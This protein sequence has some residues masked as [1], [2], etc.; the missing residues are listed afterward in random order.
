MQ[1]AGLPKGAIAI[2]IAE[3]ARISFPPGSDVWRDFG[4][5]IELMAKHMTPGSENPGIM[6]TELQRLQQQQRQ[7]SANTAL[8][9]STGGGQGGQPAAPPQAA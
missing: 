2:K 9:R 6:N 7:S 8:M 3:A 4:K 1:A 5:A